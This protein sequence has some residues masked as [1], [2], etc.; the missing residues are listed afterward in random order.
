MYT[1]RTKRCSNKK[2]KKG[3]ACFNTHSNDMCRRIPKQISDKDNIFNYIPKACPEFKKTMKCSRGEAC[4]L[5]HGWLEIIYH[6]LL[7]KT[8]LCQSNLNKR[9]CCKYGIYC[10]KVHSENEI[11]NL[12]TM[13][14]K[15]WKRYYEAYQVCD[16]DNPITKKSKRKRIKRADV[17]DSSYLQS[18]TGEDLCLLMKTVG[19]SDLSSQLYGG[20]P[21]FVPTPPESPSFESSAECS[22]QQDSRIDYLSSLDLSFLGSED[23]TDC[24]GE[25]S[26]GTVSYGKEEIIHTIRPPK[27]SR[28]SSL[29]TAAP[30]GHLIGLLL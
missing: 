23:S 1:F 15:D 11:R 21:L 17:S 22:E 12:V 10:A 26:A 29:L 13:Y 6:P 24:N 9:V 25:V 19:T 5:A 18:S 14:G 7:Y 20:S 28:I 2:C 16:S 4:Y 3:M 8:K 27:C 30:L